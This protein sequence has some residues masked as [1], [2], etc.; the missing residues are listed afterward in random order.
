MALNSIVS[1]NI[2][3]KKNLHQKVCN[4]KSKGRNHNEMFMSTEFFDI[5]YYLN[6]Y[7]IYYHSVRHSIRLNLIGMA[8]Q[9]L[10]ALFDNTYVPKENYNLIHSNIGM[11]LILERH[12][13]LQIPK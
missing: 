3:V 9:T 13:R 6:P 1:N 12:N 5:C 11:Y 4:L 8:E 7:I 2:I 10:F